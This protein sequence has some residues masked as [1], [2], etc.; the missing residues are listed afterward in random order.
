MT[1]ETGLVEREFREAGKPH[2]GVAERRVL[3]EG[4]G[5]LASATTRDLRCH[6]EAGA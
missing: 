6:H 3:D 4:V 5:H 1:R 2:D